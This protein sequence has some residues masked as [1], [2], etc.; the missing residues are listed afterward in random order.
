MS[1]CAVLRMALL[2]L[3]LH[4]GL[5]VAHPQHRQQ[6]VQR[7]PASAWPIDGFKLTDQHGAPFTQDRLMNRW[8][9]VLFGDTQC[10]TP[11]S[12]ALTALDGLVRRIAGAEVHQVTQV[13]LIARDAPHNRPDRLR[14]YMA[15]YDKAF[16]AAVGP[17]AVVDRLADDW[18]VE[19]APQETPATKP[20]SAAPHSGSLL[21]VGP[22]G[23]VRAEYLP[24]FDAAL[25]TADF[26]KS[27]ARGGRR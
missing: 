23:S 27:R 16:V 18:H 10:T 1:A 22:D 24:P 20:V 5:A 7:A 8:T 26:L 21:L 3:A 12:D 25:L 6:A 2:G 14:R 9:F 4:A 13:L 17:A 11:C 15:P 19:P